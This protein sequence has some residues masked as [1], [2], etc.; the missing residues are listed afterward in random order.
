PDT[1]GEDNITED[2]VKQYIYDVERRID[3]RISFKYAI[4]LAVPVD[5]VI[6][7]ITRRRTAYDIYVDIYPSREFEALPEAVKEWRDLAESLLQDII[8]GSIALTVPTAE[9]T[10][11]RAMTSHIMNPSIR[12]FCQVNSIFK[13]FI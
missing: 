4:P 11:I 8:T 7:Q 9:G 13:S 5:E 3:A 1:D 12:N 10:G 2:G 6:N